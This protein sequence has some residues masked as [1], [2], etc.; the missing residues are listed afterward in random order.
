MHLIRHQPRIRVAVMTQV[1]ATI[2]VAVAGMVEG[3]AVTKPILI[4]M[5]GLPRSGKTT[6]CKK[7]SKALG[8]PVVNRDTIRLALHGHA[9]LA[10]AEPFVKAISNVM[11]ESL[12]LYGYPKVICDE[13]CYS[14]A[15]R[16]ALKSPRWDTYFYEVPTSPDVCKERAIATDQA[17]LLPVIDEMW[18]RREPLADG[19][20]KVYDFGIWGVDYDPSEY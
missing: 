4:A 12:F 7:L 3:V 11:I 20:L 1:A 10:K 19:D 15:A 2:Q 5:Y 8:A 13:T 6:I 9:Y 16:D 18:S 14:Q 17:Y